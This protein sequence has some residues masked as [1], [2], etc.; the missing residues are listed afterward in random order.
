MKTFFELIEELTPEQKQKVD[1][2]GKNTTATKISQNVFPEGHDRIEI[3]LEHPEGKQKDA[4]PHPDVEDHLEKHG[5]KIKDY[6]SGLAT[7]KHGRDMK[8]G[9][10]LE[11]TKAEDKVKQAFANDPSRA[12]STQAGNLKVVISKHPHDVAGMST[13]RGWS[14]CMNMDTGSNSHYLKHDVKKGTHVA[15]LVNKDDNEIK[16]PLARI[17]L[18]PYHSSVSDHSV[19]RPEESGYG[20]GDSAFHHTVKQFAEKHYPA[21][22]AS[23]HKDDDVYDDDGNNVIFNENASD[24]DLDKALKSKNS[25]SRTQV[26]RHPNI[27]VNHILS[28]LHDPDALVRLVAARSNL[29]TPKHINTILDDKDPMIRTAA[30]R[31]INA[32]KSNV[33]KAVNDEDVTVSKSATYHPEADDETMHKF[34]SKHPMESSLIPHMHDISPELHGKLVNHESPIVRLMALLHKK[35][36]PEQIK[37]ATNDKNEGVSGWAKKEMEKERNKIQDKPEETKPSNDNMV[38]V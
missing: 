34:Y 12:A 33:D 3:P 11:K 6:K 24:K 29:L 18:K 26:L 2:W 9:R 4:E 22:D 16:K 14:S 15:Y 38:R 32:D 8:I 36:T 17:A 21:K 7:D 10:V 35:T 25:V 20:T 27:K 37:H 30:I 23:Y 5:Y 19:L 28:A 1:A 13:D 31:N